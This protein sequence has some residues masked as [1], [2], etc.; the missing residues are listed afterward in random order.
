[1]NTPVRTV[2]IRPRDFVAP[3]VIL[4]APRPD[5]IA[6]NAASL[7]SRTSA[8]IAAEREAALAER[9][10]LEAARPEALLNGAAEDV[11][12]LDHHIALAKIRIDQAEQQHAA[13]VTAEA[14]ARA[15]H[16][17]EQARRKALR[18][19]AVK[20]SGEVAKLADD[21]VVAAGKLAV[22]LGQIRE[23]ELL[24]EQANRNLPDDAELVPPG[25]AFNGKPG[26]ATCYETISEL[27]WVDTRDGSRAGGMSGDD[28]RHRAAKRVERKVYVPGTP[29]EPHTPL[30]T[31]VR[32]PGLG[33]DAA[34][35]W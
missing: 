3:R 28:L 25:E 24:I 23:R 26:T 9:E 21:Y 16:E 4:S 2:S 7:P 20:A 15:E 34:P 11:A 12:S 29:S 1:M 17:A 8:D 14:R 5:L 6:A 19:Q 22:L 32:L 31:R 27:V 13:A 33:R 18:K 10:V 30:S 35:I